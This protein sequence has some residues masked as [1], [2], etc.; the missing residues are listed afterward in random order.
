MIPMAGR[1]NRFAQAGY[2]TPKPLLQVSGLP[3]VVQAARSLPTTENTQFVVLGEHFDNNEV[4]TSV[5]K[6][7][8]NA[9]FTLLDT[10]SEGQACTCLAAINELPA[11][12]PLTIT[13]CDHGVI[14]AQDKLTELMRNSDVDIIIWVT[15]G[16]PGAI[17][18]PH[19]YGWVK[20]VGEEVRGVSVKEPLNDPINDFIITGTFTFKR[21]EI[22]RTVAQKLIERD[23][24]INGEFYVDS[25]LEDAIYMGYRARVLQV[26]HYFCWGTPNDLKTFEYWQSC[27]H[28]LPNHPYRW[29]KDRWRSDLSASNLEHLQPIEV[30][31]PG[32][33][34]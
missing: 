23:G 5:K 17:K 33:R 13:A 32:A 22:F 15:V 29:Q 28:K 2:A 31:P 3:M 9:D 18:N 10:F 11:G 6:S 12:K 25:C 19:M 20:T 21:A 26:D 24:R 34:P 30:D 27:F 14:Y 16:H 1:G 8:P 7:F 4:Q